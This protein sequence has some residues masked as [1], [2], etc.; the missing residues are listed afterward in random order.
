MKAIQVHETGGSEVLQL[1][2]VATPEPGRGEARIKVAAAGLN[3]IDV[4]HRVG[5]YDL[6]LPF[7]PGREAGGVVDA[8][9]P[10]VSEVQVGDR[11]AFAL[12]PAGY[13]EYVVL[14]AWKLVPV[15]DDVEMYPATAAMLQGMTAHYLVH[16][17]YRIRPGD[18][19]LVH[20][21]AGGVGQLLVQI[22]KLRG[23]RV[24]ATVSTEEKAALARAAGA[25]EVILY[26][27]ADFETETLRLTDNAGVQVVYDS[28]GKDTFLKGLNCLRPRGYMVLY[29]Q[30]SG[31]VGPFNPQIL[32]SKGSL[33]LTRPSL[34]HHVATRE[35]L[36]QRAEDIFGWM[37]G[38][39][40]N[41]RVDRTFPLA[42]A[43][44]AHR[45][46]EGRQTKGKVLL[47]P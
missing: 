24:I 17:S 16:D 30:A 40:L 33:F 42:A 22:A 18:S 47:I 32:N 37:A 5:L 29:G 31:P 20:A 23:A 7:I 38:G 28:V 27:Q 41:V 6:R 43:A 3:F 12:H 1:R 25:D 36:L 10:E 39:Q 26:T 9:G 34:G 21:A 35:E 14:P 13:A 2:E 45:Y 4:Y 15:P 11:V 19:A 44:E 46:I 8:V